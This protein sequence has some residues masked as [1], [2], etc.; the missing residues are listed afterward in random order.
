MRQAVAGIALTTQ[1][2]RSE[3]VH[4][5]VL[6]VHAE[7]RDH[8]I[9]CRWV[10]DQKLIIPTVRQYE[11]RRDLA[12]VGARGHDLLPPSSTARQRSIVQSE[13]SH[14]AGLPSLS[15]S[16]NVAPSLPHP[17]MQ[18]RGPSYGF[19]GIGWPA[20]DRQTQGFVS[21]VVMTCA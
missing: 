9:F 13:H 7:R 21:G 12:I 17:R 16:R 6:T 20:H 5:P 2:D 19:A 1:P 11:G 8:D 15:Y 18:A 4:L 14:F 10:T 3:S